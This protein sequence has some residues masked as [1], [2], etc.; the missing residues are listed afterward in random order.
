MRT[1]FT[2]FLVCG[3]ACA[4]LSQPSGSEGPVIR[5]SSH[6]GGMLTLQETD[7]AG[8]AGFTNDSWQ[9]E[10][11]RLYS[12]PGAAEK[13]FSAAY[14]A[15]SG[16][17]LAFENGDTLFLKRIPAATDLKGQLDYRLVGRY[18]NR[19]V[20]Y[21]WGFEWEQYLLLD[22]D[23]ARNYVLPG[24]PEFS[25]FSGSVWGWG[26]AYGDS[27]FTLIDLENRRDATLTFYNYEIGALKQFSNGFVLQLYDGNGG[28]G[29][30]YYRAGW[31]R[32]GG[33][34]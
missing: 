32:L 13:E 8:F 10:K 5:L 25:S 2:L 33:G 24:P 20:I 4:A 1:R 9:E 16:T 7:S 34:D 11:Y 27:E 23:G 26:N 17:R 14:P 18:E 22:L 3:L 19:V 12:D 28:S 6:H 29:K 21:A 30:R 15:L 31:E